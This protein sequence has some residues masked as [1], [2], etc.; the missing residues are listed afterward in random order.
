KFPANEQPKTLLDI[1]NSTKTKLHDDVTFLVVN[2]HKKLLSMKISAKAENLKKIR[3]EIKKTAKKCTSCEKTINDIVLAVDE[4]CQNIIRH[5]YK[6]Y[7]DG[8]NIIVE[9]SQNGDNIIVYLTDFAPSVE[10]DKIVPR[11]FDD[12]RAGGLGTSFIREI[13]DKVEF[14]KPPKNAGNLLKMVK[15]V[16]K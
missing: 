9:V 7:R 8:N 2:H 5:A 10:L 11:D 4:A 13:M 16:K 6:E 3:T 12:I 14:I 1:L 15:K